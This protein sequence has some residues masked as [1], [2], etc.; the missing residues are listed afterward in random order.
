MMDELSESAG[1][2]FVSKINFVGGFNLMP[3]PY[4]SHGA[5]GIPQEG[6]RTSNHRAQDRNLLTI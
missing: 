5:R 3:A 1:V 4:R 2:V 6:K